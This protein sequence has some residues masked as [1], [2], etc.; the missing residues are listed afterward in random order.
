ME[1]ERTPSDRTWQA[2]S[3]HKQIGEQREKVTE[4]RAKL[5]QLLAEWDEMEADLGRLVPDPEDCREV[6]QNDAIRSYLVRI[7]N[8]D[9]GP[10]VMVRPLEN[11]YMLA[12]PEE[13]P[14]IPDAELEHLPNTIPVGASV[15]VDTDS[16]FADLAAASLEEITHGDSPVGELIPQ[17]V[18][19]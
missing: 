13:L 18:R 5:A 11:A 12:W 14:T 10:T 3:L 15:V 7:E 17:R 16:E 19:S 2:V 6:I 9:C 1:T 8:D 4:A